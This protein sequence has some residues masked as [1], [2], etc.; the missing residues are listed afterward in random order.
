M[1]R[2]GLTRE[3]SERKRKALQAHDAKTREQE[4]AALTP[5][6]RARRQR[7]AASALIQRIAREREQIETRKRR[8]AS[9]DEQIAV[10]QARLTGVQRSESHRVDVMA[11]LEDQIDELQEHHDAV[12][13][14]IK[15]NL[16]AIATLEKQRGA[17]AAAAP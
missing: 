17:M 7:R 5:A 3:E 12:I 11:R 4:E 8:L 2:A 15:A 13:A 10:K 14:G 16:T 1:A 9:L 6:Q